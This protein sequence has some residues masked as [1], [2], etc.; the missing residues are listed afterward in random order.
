MKARSLLSGTEDQVTFFIKLRTTFYSVSM[1][2]NLLRK[3]LP[4]QVHTQVRGMRA[5]KDMTGACFDVPENYA[6][7]IE[8][9][10][11][12]VLDQRGTLDFEM[13]IAKDLP[14][15]KED[16]YNNQGGHGGG[17]YQGR[18]GRGGY[19]DQRGGYGGNNYSSGYQGRGGYN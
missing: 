2:W 19:G 3:Y 14:E 8:D 17:G 4:D 1:V 7:R 5:F 13:G 15:L 16:D 6:Q 12:Y 9:S 10:Y 11:N 18:G